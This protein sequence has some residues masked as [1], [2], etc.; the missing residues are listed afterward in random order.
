M[1]VNM[2][3]CLLLFFLKFFVHSLIHLCSTFL[4]ISCYACPTVHVVVLYT[5]L[6]L[7]YEHIYIYIHIPVSVCTDV[8][9][10][11]MKLFVYPNLS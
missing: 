10:V 1:Y 6:S 7:A 3:L 5:V 11:R 4:L 8:V 2:Y 9:C